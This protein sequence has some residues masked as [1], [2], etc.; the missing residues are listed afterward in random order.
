MTGYKCPLCG[1][2]MNRDLGIF[3]EHTN[4]H[5]IDKIK[6][7]HPEWI[8][9]DGACQMCVDYMKMELSG[10]VGKV[11]IG[12]GE[13]KKRVTLG[14]AML[15]IGV[16]LGSWM[17]QNK[18][19]VIWRLMLLFPFFLASLGIIQACEKTCAFLA[20]MGRQNMDSGVLQM[21]DQK[22]ISQLRWRG[23]LIFIKSLLLAFYPE[24]L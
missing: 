10:D 17:S 5:I 15:V 20:V 14:W 24:L 16:F 9:S 1:K 23:M 12:P 7:S 21:V 2:M 19:P 22:V 13:R 8:E 3:L 11:N 4:E 18:V 6:E